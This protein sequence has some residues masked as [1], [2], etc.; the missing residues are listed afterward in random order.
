M[1]I[2]KLSPRPRYYN[3]LTQPIA[4]VTIVELM[5]LASL[6]DNSFVFLLGM[7]YNLA[8]MAAVYWELFLE[9]RT[10]TRYDLLN[11][12]PHQLIIERGRVVGF[13]TFPAI[14]STIRRKSP[15]K[16]RVTEHELE[17]L[18]N[19]F[20]TRSGQYDRP[21]Q[22][23][24]SEDGPA[25]S[26]ALMHHGIMF[27]T[28]ETT[29][30]HRFYRLEYD[31]ARRMLVF[32]KPPNEAEA[33]AGI[34]QAAVRVAD[35]IRRDRVN[36]VIYLLAVEAIIGD[37]VYVMSTYLMGVM[38]GTGLAWLHPTLHTLPLRIRD[39]IN[40]LMQNP[41]AMIL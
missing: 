11:D 29:L 20:L 10:A 41:R 25:L 17:R 9:L 21:S 2:V 38:K 6:F 34:T 39:H 26:E 8:L 32:Y 19:M 27:T 14:S 4:V 31:S 36:D 33:M 12:E 37:G 16:I 15:K 3:I 22:G 24:G 30:F 13:Y 5:L 1:N 23:R 7:A 35:I 28:E 40:W 18:L